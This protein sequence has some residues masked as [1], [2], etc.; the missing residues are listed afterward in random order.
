MVTHEADVA[1]HV[2]RVLT[3]RDGEIISDV[4]QAPRPV[5]KERSA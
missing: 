2:G 1:A 3:F 4:A 5:T